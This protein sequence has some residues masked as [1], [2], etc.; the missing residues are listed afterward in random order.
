LSIS[1]TKSLV[2]KKGRKPLSDIELFSLFFHKDFL[3]DPFLTAMSSFAS[4]GTNYLSYPN[5]REYFP[6]FDLQLCKLSLIEDER[7]TNILC[8]SKG[9]IQV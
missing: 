7:K 2:N 8:P 3:A 6:I 9:I 4:L 1:S 5:E